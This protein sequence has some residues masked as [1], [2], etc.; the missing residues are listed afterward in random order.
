MNINP[1]NTAFVARGFIPAGLRSSPQADTKVCQIDVVGF[2]GAAAQPSGDKSP[3]HRY[4]IERE[5]LS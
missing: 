3:R 1:G 5:L 4:C 2:F